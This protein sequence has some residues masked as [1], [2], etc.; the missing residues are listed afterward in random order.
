MKK[1]SDSFHLRNLQLK[2][3]HKSKSHPVYYLTPLQ[4]MEYIYSDSK[5]NVSQF[6]SSYKV[7]LAKNDHSK[8]NIKIYLL[9]T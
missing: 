6:T 3:I 4:D 5:K 1:K 9:L 8:L 7:D 2:Y